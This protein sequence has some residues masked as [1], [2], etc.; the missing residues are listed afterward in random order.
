M[1]RVPG[2]VPRPADDIDERGAVLQLDRVSKSFGG[3]T[4]LSH[5]SA[6]VSEGSVTGL[7]GPNGAGK[8][9]LINCIT[10]FYSIDDGDIYFFGDRISNMSVS[11]V[12]GRRLGRTFQNIALPPDMTV[13]DNVLLG[14]HLDAPYGYLQSVFHTPRARQM[15]QYAYE[16]A[17]EAL[18]F[19]GLEN[20]AQHLLGDLPH[21]HQKL[22]ELARAVV[23]RPRLLL[24]D[25]PGAGV[26]ATDKG[27][28]TELIR[29]LHRR[30]G[31]TIVIVE[32]DM[33]MVMELSD[34]VIVLNWG[35]V[36][37]HGTPDEVQKDP[38]VIESYLG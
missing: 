2:T 9:T 33:N 8:T 19:V 3:I 34:D 15:E 16:S 21:G 29:A 30:L 12:A 13:I 23:Q 7:I 10:G 14:T 17:A 24:L 31:C 1:T 4:A 20:R 38:A 35:H 36:I 26:A 11:E 37:A 5:V 18:K 6:S 32:H 22:V 28:L 27:P 25:E